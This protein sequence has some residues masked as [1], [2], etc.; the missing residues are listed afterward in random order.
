MIV[1]GADTGIVAVGGGESRK[2][3]VFA[4][5]F[6]MTQTTAVKFLCFA[7]ASTSVGVTFSCTGTSI[8]CD[9][10]RYGFSGSFSQSDR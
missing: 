10:P 2:I 7:P 6:T 3:F 8:A 5:F 9:I 4:V 1:E